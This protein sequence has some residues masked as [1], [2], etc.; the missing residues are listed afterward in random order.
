MNSLV[1]LQHVFHIAQI[2]G[3]VGGSEGEERRLLISP[4]LLRLCHQLQSD[5]IPLH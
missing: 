2:H 5:S 1:R 3:Y 4:V